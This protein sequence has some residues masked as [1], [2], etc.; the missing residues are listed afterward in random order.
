VDSHCASG[1]TCNTGT[2]SPTCLP[3]QATNG[4]CGK[5]DDCADGLVCNQMLDP[6]HCTPLPGKGEKCYFKMCAEGLECTDQ[7][8]S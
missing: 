7:Y 1:L 5:D 4:S 8:C 6:R 2:T 3:P